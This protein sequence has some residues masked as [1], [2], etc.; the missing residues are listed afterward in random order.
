MH[1]AEN[2]LL[3]GPFPKATY[4]N[5][6]L[7]FHSGDKLLL[8][9]DGV[10]EAIGPDGQEFGRDGLEAFLLKGAGQPAQFLDALFQKISTVAQQDD[11]TAVFVQF[12]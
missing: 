7:P 8:Y 9:T 12:D 11:L 3:I 1:L 6:S 2:G 5:V 10:V 4:T